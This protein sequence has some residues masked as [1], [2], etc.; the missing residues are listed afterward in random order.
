MNGKKAKKLRQEI[1]FL[2]A[3]FHAV[4]GVSARD[5]RKRRDKFQKQY[6]GGMNSIFIGT[7][8]LVLLRVGIRLDVEAHFVSL[9]FQLDVEG[10]HH[11]HDGDG[12][13]QGHDNG[14][15]I[16]SPARATPPTIAKE[17]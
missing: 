11:Q 5:G 8:R 14:C 17:R 9:V 10:D 15:G 3:I 16:V 6:A 13:R 1:L 4:I 7:E 2:A 12:E